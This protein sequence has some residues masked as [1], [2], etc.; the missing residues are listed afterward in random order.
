MRRSQ[1]A[2]L[3]I[4]PQPSAGLGR[5]RTA[6]AG[7]GKTAAVKFDAVLFDAGGVL[8]QPGGFAAL[9]K[10]AAGHEM[11]RAEILDHRRAAIGPGWE[12]GRTISEIHALLVAGCR[13]TPDELPDLL[14]ALHDGVVD[15]VLAAFVTA[16]RRRYRVGIVMNN[17]EDARRLVCERLGLD[18]L[19]DVIVISAEEG[20]A[21]PNPEIYL[22]AAARLGVAP[23]RCLFVDDTQVCVDGA[24]AVG[25]SA[26]RFTSTD[27]T[28]LAVR[29]R[30]G[31]IEHDY[32]AAGG[33]VI[34]GDRVL[35]LERPS[36]G[37]VRLPKGHVE[38]GETDR[39]AAVREVGE[40]AGYVDV[41]DERDLGVQ[42]VEFDF[43]PPEG[44]SHH[45]VRRERSFRM[46]L[47]SDAQAERAEG[48]LKFVPRWMS[49]AEAAERLTFDVEREWLRRALEVSR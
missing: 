3:P 21:K 10:W 30:L 12:G 48:D 45:V 42:H 27:E 35:V 6:T 9:D 15:P 38:A 26:V 34:E 47:R 17:G 18:G 13:I 16:L 14:A 41:E 7:P 49:L 5:T 11:T 40:E 8:V 28:L 39:D 4:S 32:D 24:E 25:M 37:E 33:V 36:R 23:Q 44:S 46:R 22:T 2:R 29:R 43:F 19:A 31:V 1:A 20:V